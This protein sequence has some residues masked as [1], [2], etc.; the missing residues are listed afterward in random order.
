MKKSRKMKPD[1]SPVS[2]QVLKALPLLS[3]ISQLP[4]KGKLDYMLNQMGGSQ[5]IFDALTEITGNYIK[6]KIPMK[7]LHS[8]LVNQHRRVIK[9]FH[10]EK[11]RKNP[12]LRSL[13]I[14]QSGGYIPY[15]VPA[16]ASYIK[17]LLNKFKEKN[18]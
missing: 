9:K 15:L 2:K 12:K 10:C 4:N 18:E 5:E 8:K 14:K 16:A 6:D 13:A 7:K 11:V 1:S 3:F 17:V